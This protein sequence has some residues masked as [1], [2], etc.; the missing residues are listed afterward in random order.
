MMI[1]K[2]V[3]M[4]LLLLKRTVVYFLLLLFFSCSK[5]TQLDPDNFI[6]KCDTIDFSPLRDRT[7]HFR[8]IAS[9]ENSN[10]YFVGIYSN[11]CSPYIVDYNYKKKIINDISNDLVLKHCADYLTEY[12]I[13]KIMDFYITLDLCVVFVDSSN[14]IYINPTQQAE[15]TLMKKRAN[16]NK[17]D[18]L[19]FKLY[20]K[21]WYIRQ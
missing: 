9:T 11:R 5:K 3:Y 6:S 8:S 19:S 2:N 4:C 13:K 21:D 1:N 16:L 20:K 12:E 17:R 15:P 18:N 14:N 7:I 10:I